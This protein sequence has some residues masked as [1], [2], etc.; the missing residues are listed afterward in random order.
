MQRGDEGDCFLRAL[1]AMHDNGPALLAADEIAARQ[2]WAHKMLA[3][4]QRGDAEGDYRRAWL[5][6]AVLED[7]FHIRGLWYEGPK[8]SLR[9]LAQLDRPTYDA[10]CIALKPG[11]SHQAIASAVSLAAGPAGSA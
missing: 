4:I 7:Y 2:V 5:L 6:Q 11:A 1:D 3:R 9:W 8:R 10:L